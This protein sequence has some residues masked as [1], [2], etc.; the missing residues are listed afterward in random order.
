M[1]EKKGNQFI[2]K[3]ENTGKTLGTYQTKE[4]AESRM[5]QIDAFKKNGEAREKKRDEK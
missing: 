3:G 4:Q 2:I 5:R 1:I